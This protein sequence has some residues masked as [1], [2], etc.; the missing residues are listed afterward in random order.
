M[1]K[2]DSKCSNNL[3]EIKLEDFVVWVDPLDGTNEF[4]E[5][6]TKKLRKIQKKKI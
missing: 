3:R 6:V 2:I 4:I 5:G 1:L